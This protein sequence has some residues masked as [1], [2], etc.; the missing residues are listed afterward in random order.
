MGKTKKQL[1]EELQQL[2][3]LLEEQSKLLTNSSDRGTNSNQE[4][5][6]IKMTKMVRVVSLYHG[7]LNLKTS[8]QAD[9]QI[10]TF[11]FF[12]YEQPIFYS[13][14]MKCVNTQRRLFTDGFCYIYDKEV[15]KAHYLE[16]Q[17]ETLLDKDML[18]NFMNYDSDFIK[19][20]YLQLPIQQRI[21]LL[22]TIAYKLNDNENIDRNKIDVLAQ[23]ADVDIY[24]LANKLK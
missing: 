24:E 3:I 14:L 1:E 7:V 2:K 9:A 12:G 17:Y 20:R 8:S 6:E 22:E 15:I 5:F 16:K 10:F 21:T 18:L 13:D 23:V 4:D 11:N 19:T